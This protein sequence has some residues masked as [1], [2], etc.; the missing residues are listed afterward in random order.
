MFRFI[1]GDFH[2]LMK[3]VSEE[4][5]RSL[6]STPS[7]PSGGNEFWVSLPYHVL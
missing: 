7:T 2:L 4:L 5:A 6:P 3:E 1:L